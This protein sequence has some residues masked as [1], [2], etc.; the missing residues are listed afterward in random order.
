MNL[1][2]IYRTF[3]SNTKEYTF[4]SASYGTFSQTDHIFGHKASLSRYKKIKITP[5]ILSDHHRLNLDFNITTEN[6]QTRGNQKKKLTN[7]WKIVETEI[8]D[9]PEFK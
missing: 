9:F 4:F 3:H 6:L 7:E 8:K 2:D 1:T 5:C